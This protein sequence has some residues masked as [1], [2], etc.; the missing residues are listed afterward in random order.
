MF[1]YEERMSVF[2]FVSV[3]AWEINFG[4]LHIEAVMFIST[5]ND[6]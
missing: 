6:I 4:A 5:V 2:A 3:C 1:K